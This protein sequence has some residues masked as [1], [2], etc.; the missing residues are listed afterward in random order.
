MASAFSALAEPARRRLLDQL[1]TGPRPVGALAL[2]TGLSQP[3]T[4]RHLRILREAELVEAQGV[5]QL[6][7]YRLR[8]QGFEALE[9]WLAP[10][11]RLWRRGLD[12]LEVH[13]ETEE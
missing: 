2:A 9:G 4:S 7:V 5:G 13:L 11:A 10:Y 8:P 3:N 1:L 6:R 12:A